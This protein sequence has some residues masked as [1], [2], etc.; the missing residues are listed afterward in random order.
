MTSD[1]PYRKGMTK[2]KALSILQEEAGNQ[3]HSDVVKAMERIVQS[4]DLP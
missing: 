2:Q 1:R 4:I 3:S